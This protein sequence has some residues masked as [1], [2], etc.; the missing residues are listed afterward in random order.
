VTASARP[1]PPTGGAPVPLPQPT[2][3]PVGRG[4]GR[5]GAS[6]IVYAD[7]GSVQGNYSKDLLLRIAS[8]WSGQP[9]GSA[10]VE[11]VTK[12]DQWT[13]QGG[14]RNLRPLWKYSFPDGQ[15]VYVS[16]PTGQVV[17][18]TT[19]GS[20]IGAE[21]GPIPHWIYYTPLRVQQ[22]LWSNLIIWTSGIATVAA[23]L[24]LCV[25]ISLYS[26]SKRYKYLG[27]PSSVPYT[28]DKR[29]HMTLGLF[30]G[31]VACT[32]AFSGML[33]MDPFPIQRTNGGQGGPGGGGRI[34]SPTARIQAV[35]RASRFQMDDYSAKSPQMALTQLG[36]VQA[37]QLDF[38][39]FDEQPVYVAALNSKETRIIPVEGAPRTEYD[40]DRIL[41]MVTNAAKPYDVTEKRLLTQYDRYY[42]DRHHDRPLP[43][44]FVKLSDPEHTQLYID[45]R[46]GRIVG[47]HSD[48]SS[49]VTRWLY[50]GLHSMDFPWLYN[51]R[52]AWDIVVLTL[53]LGGLTL[54]VTSM[55][56]AWGLLRRKLS[57]RRSPRTEPVSQRP[58]PMSASGD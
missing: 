31:L 45:Q 24:G 49:F 42:L 39:S 44:L 56:L 55:I 10:K 11:E 27:A 14:V 16:E 22:K 37:K 33:S 48:A 15:Q 8:Q 2:P 6:A 40:R 13:L 18:A 5:G 4:R 30:F 28:G 9:G 52:P 35:L 38:T 17:Q 46:S 36:N 7:D 23:L 20:R 41:D 58:E 1:Q 12:T 29:L 26:P 47:Q 34:V 50:H 32:W 57:F 53:M 25:G 51:Y 3:P 54:S 43:V 21:L 19:L